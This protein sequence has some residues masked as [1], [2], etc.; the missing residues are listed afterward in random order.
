MSLLFTMV[1]QFLEGGKGGGGG[2]QSRI[3]LNF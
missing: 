3:T 2:Y 1:L